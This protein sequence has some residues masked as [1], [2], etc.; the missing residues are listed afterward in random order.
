MIRIDQVCN[1]YYM[2]HYYMN[3]MITC[4]SVGGISTK[5]EAKTKTKTKTV[6]V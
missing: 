5:N 4:I 1:F 2:A 3:W 6:E